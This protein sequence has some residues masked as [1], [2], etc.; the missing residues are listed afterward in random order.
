MLL[1]N[2]YGS[3]T[4]TSTLSQLRRLDATGMRL[5]RSSYSILDHDTNEHI[6]NKERININTTFL[7]TC[8][9]YYHEARMYTRNIRYV[10]D[11]FVVWNHGEEELQLFLQHINSKNKTNK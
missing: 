3:E 6:H 7:D 8:R 5:L 4:W 10:D 11:T 2:M 1:V 9:N